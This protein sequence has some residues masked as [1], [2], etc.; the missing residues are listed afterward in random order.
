[1]SKDIEFLNNINCGLL[2]CSSIAGGALLGLATWHMSLLL[3]LLVFVLGISL[4][5]FSNLANGV[6][7]GIK[8]QKALQGKDG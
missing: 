8:H 7:L 3:T 1:M 4:I 5:A 2:T 6:K